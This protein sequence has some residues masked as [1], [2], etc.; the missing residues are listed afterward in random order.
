MDSSNFHKL[1][2]QPNV[3][4]QVTVL[5][6]TL[7]NEWIARS[8]LSWQRAIIILAGIF[9]G[10]LL[11]ATVLDGMLTGH[12][13]V[14]FWRLTVLLPTSAL[15]TI[16]SYHLLMTLL[17]NA[18]GAFR[19]LLVLGA[20][21]FDTLSLTIST[22]DRRREWLSLVIG[23]V[24]GMFLPIQLWN[25]PETA[26]WLKL[27]WR[28]CGMLLF[29][30]A[31]WGIYLSAAYVQAINAL[32]SRPLKIDIFD[33]QPLEPIAQWGFGLSLSFIVSITVIILI[34]PDPQRY[35]TLGWLVWFT[36][37]ILVAVLAFFLP[38]NGIH[39]VMAEAKDRELNELRQDLVEMYQTWKHNVR[40][41]ESPMEDM[42]QLSGAIAA[43][44]AYEK[45]IEEAAE[46]PYSDGTLQRLFLSTLLPA[47][48][49]GAQ[50][51]LEFIA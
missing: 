49:W 5:A 37:L 9:A 20:E 42:D 24:I 14:Q 17:S 44:L 39:R 40:S 48:A 23:V 45:R 21:D 43:G 19:Q 6:P 22:L 41:K 34:T 18:I 30:I 46:W 7:M 12:A 8:G 36:S 26:V 2:R 13:N 32:S 11:V 47:V 4:N 50:L 31:A 28:F 33:P 3:C 35:L 1:D 51:V 38:L 27:Y 10:L 29:G 16:L 15:Y 25:G